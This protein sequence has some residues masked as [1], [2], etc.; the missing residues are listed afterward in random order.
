MLTN[1]IVVNKI[2]PFKYLLFLICHHHTDAV[3]WKL[4]EIVY[5]C[6]YNM[7]IMFQNDIRER[8]V[9]MY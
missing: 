7:S 4:I 1:N 3:Q 8:A 5:T 2:T 6:V 9:D